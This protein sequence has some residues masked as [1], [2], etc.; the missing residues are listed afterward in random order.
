MMYYE[1]GNY[2]FALMRL[3]L[4]LRVLP[5]SAGPVET[6]ALHLFAALLR[7]SV[8][9]ALPEALGEVERWNDVTKFDE[10]EYHP[11]RV[12]VSRGDLR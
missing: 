3:L 4:H 2:R 6:G 10:T 12:G 11:Y 7:F 9:G 8:N 1:A 5:N